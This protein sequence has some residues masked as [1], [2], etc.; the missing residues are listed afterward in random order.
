[1]NESQY[2]NK[3]QKVL[4]ENNCKVWREVIP[5][6]HKNREYPYRID[7]IF[8]RD[9]LGYIAVE[10][11]NTHS[12]RQGSIFAKAILQIQKYRNL[13][14][15]DGKNINKWCV[16]S[17][18]NTSFVSADKELNK[19]VASEVLYFIKTFFK[20]MYKISY[21]E[22]HEYSYWNRISIDRLAKDSINIM[23]KP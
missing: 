17:P 22:L 1:M 10:G 18:S 13:T 3:I 12:L 19:A 2:L 4:E 8:Y 15:F 14:Y 5:D 16:T 9:D 7:L 21:L 11:K 6:Q 23:K 20:Y